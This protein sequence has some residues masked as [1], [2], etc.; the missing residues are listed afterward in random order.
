M[1]LESYYDKLKAKG[2]ITEMGDEVWEAYAEIDK[3]MEEFHI[4]WRRDQAEAHRI[5]SQTYLT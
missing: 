3:A 4:T 2:L 1:E 5:A